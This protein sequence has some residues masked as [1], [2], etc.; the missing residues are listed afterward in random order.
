MNA[1]MTFDFEEQPVRAFVRDGAE[2]FVAVDVCRCL[3]LGNTSRA[4]AR[5]P[6]DEKGVTTGNTLGGNQTMSCVTEP[7]LYRLIFESRKPEAERL[8][9]FVFH[10]VL[11]ALRRTGAYA[12]EPVIEDVR[13][14]L[15]M[16]REMRL[17][18]GRKA[19]QALWRTLALPQ[20]QDE[21]QVPA[22]QTA[23]MQHITDFLDE[24]TVRGGASEVDA[25]TLHRRY[26]QWAAANNA[27]YM[28]A[29]SFGRYV[30]K[31]GIA[32]RRSCGSIYT[33]IRIAPSSGSVAR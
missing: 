10:E 19:A 31:A 28:I 33:G 6:D 18:Y 14:D 11:P 22:P 2:W 4:I 9:R 13:H 25:A 12:P 1:L 16:V 8:K 15:A 27:P 26:Q 32:R 5:L 24:C 29:S 30:V 23:M 7:G 17:T 21:A 3:D 20:P